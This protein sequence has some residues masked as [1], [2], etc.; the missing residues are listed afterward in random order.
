MD[1]IDGMRT[2]VAVVETGSF[3]AAS[4]R[5]GISNKLVSKY[6][7]TLEAR[8]RMKVLHRTTRSMSLTSE[9]RTYLEGCRRV[10]S[11]IDALE[12]SLD[13]SGEFK[14]KIRIAAPLT[15]GET[16]VTKAALAFMQAHPK[17]VIEIDM[18][19][20]YV[21]LAQ[22]G[23]DVAIRIGALKDSSLKARK[24]GETNLFVVAAPSY[25][26]VHGEPTHPD[27]LSAHICI[28]DA[29]NPDPNR[30]PFLIEGKTVHIPVAGPFI[31]NSAPACLLPTYA[32]KG[33]YIC[34]NVFLRDDLESGRLVRL[35]SGFHSRTIGIHALRLSSEHQNPKVAAF[36]EF[37][38]KQFGS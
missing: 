5:L 26:D 7:A 3:S 21:D 31:A 18:S 33:I 9:G 34:P 35:L 4:K 23:Y 13:F 37:M 38:R 27:E 29:N 6:I 25:I 8:L 1:Q 32:G 20:E 19:D 12:S 24:L 11:E 17:M 10:L 22:G 2:F 28:R 30:W 36:V 14:G 16:V 15:Y